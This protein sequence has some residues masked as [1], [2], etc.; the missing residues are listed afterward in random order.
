MYESDVIR[1]SDRD[2]KGLDSAL[3]AIGLRLSLVQRDNPIP[4]SFWGESEA[5]LL[6]D[7][8]YARADTP[9]HSILHESGHYACMAPNRR[10]AVDTDAG[11]DDDEE[12]AVCYWQVLATDWLTA[13]TRHDMLADMDRWGYTFRLGSARAWFETDAEDA[14]AWLTRAGLID[15]V[16]GYLLKRLRRDFI[17]S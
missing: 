14:R 6:D 16:T 11:G 15:P 5:G 13:V 3:S 2:V 17:R 1:L 8:L 12:V 7:C 9:L 4:G 10:A